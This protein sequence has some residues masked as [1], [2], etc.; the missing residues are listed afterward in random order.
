METKCVKGVPKYKVEKVVKEYAMDKW[1]LDKKEEK[2]PGVL[3]LY[4]IRP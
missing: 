3:D 1:R 2:S 4:F